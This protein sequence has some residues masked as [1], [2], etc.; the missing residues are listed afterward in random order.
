[1]SSDKKTFDIRRE[2]IGILLFFLS[3]AMM[4]M[5]YLPADITGAL[6]SFIKSVGFGSLGPTAYAIPVILAY[7]AFDYF[8]EKRAGVTKVRIT[9]ILLLI[10]LISSFMALV[11][12]DFDLFEQ[13]CA[14]DDG[15][16]KATKAI[17]LLWNS[18]MDSSLIT[19]TGASGNAIAGGLI[20]GGIAVAIHS[21]LGTVVGGIAV[22]FFCLAQV[23]LVFHISLKKSAQKAG[24]AIKRG[25]TT[26]Y[27]N[28]NR[29]REE[30][31]ARVNTR[32]TYGGPS[33]FVNDQ[34]QRRHVDVTGR[35]EIETD[36]FNTKIPVDSKSG[37]IDVSAAEFGA[38]TTPH[39]DTLNYGEKAHRVPSE[40]HKADFTYTPTPKNPPPH[41]HG[42][43][44]VPSFLDKRQQDF[45]D[46]SGG[47]LPTPPENDDTLPYEVTSGATTTIRRPRVDTDALGPVIDEQPVAYA[48]EAPA[49]PAVPVPAPSATVASAAAPS[50][51]T[52]N[53]P[54]PNKGFSDT[55]GRI[56]DTGKANA[57]PSVDIPSAPATGKVVSKRYAVYKPAPT[58]LL[59]KDE[60][61]MT[62]A[63]SNQ[64]LRE[65][66]A[67]LEQAL[68]SFGIDS[69][70]VN[71]TH[72][73]AITRFE[74]TLATGTKVNRV[75][76]L[77]DDIQ[78]AMAAYS[79]RIEAPIPGKSAIGIEIPNDKTQA[80]HL[81]DL[82]EDKGFKGT[83]PLTVALG[84]DIPGK[85]IF[86]DLAKMPH[87]LIAGQTGSGKSV[88]INTILC[89]I[90]CKS[91]PDDVRLIMVDPKVVELSIYNGIPHLIMP[92]VT[93]AKKVS[94][95]LKWAVVEMERRYRLFSESDVRNLDGYNEYLKY[96]GEKTLPLILI[97][98]DELADLMTVAG[99]DVETQI[100]RLA[101]KARAAGIHL[102]IATQRPSVDVITGVIKAN[103]PSRIAFSVASG[104]DSRTI[105]DQVGAEKLLGKGDMLYYPGTANKPIRGQGAFVSDKEV[106]TIVNFLKNNYGARYD[107]SI[108][109]SVNNGVG[110]DNDNG[111]GDS[112]SGGGGNAED[113]LFEQ[114]VEVVIEAGSASSSILQRR[115][116][117]GYPRASRLIDL[118]E[119]KGIIGPFEG[120]KPRKVLVTQIDWL[121]M[122]AKGGK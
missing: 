63:N 16:A 62:S 89:S 119:K 107:E 12:M 44:E 1:M 110:A 122:K 41:T 24:Q 13:L 78:M 92:V 72:G 26:V 68:K 23:V 58:N 61:S 106:E 88:C 36:P 32:Q 11:S 91:S 52:I 77:Q 96:N 90:L 86:C 14:G 47:E 34:G 3:V 103:L 56:V 42:K 38:D 93:E 19:S 95:L 22:V 28:V 115:L 85:P 82:L 80:V 84:K 74:L 102:I 2:A 70:V 120:S 64:E 121:E 35:T 76:S 71:I 109:E 43:M 97:I 108:I 45:F 94:N 9:S 113:D 21:V 33:P 104:V 29:A 30:H 83:T 7:M 66:A 39:P 99:K 73:P 75:L 111:G 118:L 57:A 4:L 20:G 112:G 25:T 114:A 5:Y 81:R 37:F 101:A 54:S 65:K 59:S 60:K 40:Q 50:Q 31:Q 18:G 10:V 79:V 49:A 6:G 105:L 100:S 27:R 8:L 15:E 117:V 55:E 46:L 17:S 48:P 116:G 67:T 53:K 87:L 51:I 98:I 69:Q